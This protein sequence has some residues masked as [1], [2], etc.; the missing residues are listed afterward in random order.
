MSSW[1]ILV[2][3]IV[4]SIAVAILVARWVIRRLDWRVRR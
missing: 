3:H 4:I 1:G 2:F